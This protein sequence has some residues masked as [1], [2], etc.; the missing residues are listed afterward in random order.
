MHGVDEPFDAETGEL[1]L[2]AQEFL[3][4][5]F[6]DGALL[7]LEAAGLPTAN[8]VHHLKQTLRNTSSPPDV[9]NEA[10]VALAAK[11]HGR[12][13]GT[14]EEP[15]WD[16]LEPFVSTMD[17]HS[18]VSTPYFFSLFCSLWMQRRRTSPEFFVFCPNFSLRSRFTWEPS[19]LPPPVMAAD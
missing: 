5:C 4:D 7:E 10:I 17:N 12:Y 1:T 18:N 6:S 2:D 16:S 3:E 8:I 13:F 14:L 9:C 19:S 11:S 15:D